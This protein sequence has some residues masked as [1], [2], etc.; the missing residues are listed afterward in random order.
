MEKMLILLTECGIPIKCVDFSNYEGSTMYKKILE[1]D[2]CMALF[3]RSS[4]VSE[5]L[6]VDLKWRVELEGAGF[7]WKILGLDVQ[8][9]DYVEWVFHQD[10]Y[11]RSGQNYLHNQFYS[12]MRIGNSTNLE[13][14]LKVL[15]KNRKLEYLS[16]NPILTLTIK[17]FVFPS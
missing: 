8:E 6:A 11:A 3:T 16:V 12:C 5:K 10:A 9:V 7:D 4:M 1:R 14:K 15:A 17:K 2:P 13:P